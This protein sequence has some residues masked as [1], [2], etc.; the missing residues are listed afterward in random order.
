MEIIKLN[1]VKVVK[2]SVCAIGF[3]DGV[4]LAHK[5]LI[6]ETIKIANKLNLPKVVITFDVHPKSVLFDLDYKYI[7]PLSKKIDIFKKFDLDYL[8]II[9]FTKGKAALSPLN[10]IDTYL[11]NIHTLV[12]GFDFKFG[13]RGSGNVKTLLNDPH[14][15]TIVLNEVTYEGFKVGST[16]IKDLIMSGQVDKVIEIL[17][18]YYSVKGEVVHG[19]AQGRLLGYPTANIDTTLYLVPKSGVYATLTKVKDIWYNSMSSVGHNP[20]LNCNVKLSVESHILDFDEEI[21][22]EIIE[23]KF[24][25]RLRD[26]EK[27]ETIEDLVKKID[28]DKIDTIKILKDV[29]K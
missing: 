25:K 23:T 13:V 28:Q 10:F 5:Q 26:E 16:H 3:F 4:H 18:D 20:T 14:F 29:S 7:T 8:Y 22:G 11:S 9:E 12:C 21:Y 19:A 15:K 27:F 1:G 2:D 6:N 17:G 24:V